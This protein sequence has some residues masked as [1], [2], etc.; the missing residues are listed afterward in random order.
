MGHLVDFAAIGMV[1]QHQRPLKTD[2]PAI[3][4]KQS[5]FQIAVLNAPQTDNRLTQCISPADDFSSPLSSASA[6]ASHYLPTPRGGLD[7]SGTKTARCKM[8]LPGVKRQVRDGNRRPVTVPVAM[9]SVAAVFAAMTRFS[10][11]LVAAFVFELGN[12]FV[13]AGYRK[14]SAFSVCNRVYFHASVFGV[15]RRKAARR[16]SQS[17]QPRGNRRRTIQYSVSV[18]PSYFSFTNSA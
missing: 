13:D 1:D 2:S 10:R 15:G 18:P 12:K 9:M 7:I 6:S 14:S 16:F 17:F 5:F 4:N 11:I 3:L 8:Q